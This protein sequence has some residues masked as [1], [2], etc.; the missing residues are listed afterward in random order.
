MS[1][2]RKPEISIEAADLV[3]VP[4]RSARTK[5]QDVPAE[6]I[7]EAAVRTGIPD[8]SQTK[9]AKNPAN[10]VSG[11]ER[12]AR[13]AARKTRPAGSGQ[14]GAQ[15]G[16]PADGDDVLRE[17]AIIKLLEYA[18]E[19]KILSYEELSDYLP[20]HISNSDK[21][22]QVLALLEANNVQLIEEENNGEDDGDS[23]VRKDA[24]AGKKRAARNDKESSLV[25]DPIRLYLREIGREHLLTGEQEIELSRQMEEGE[26]IITGVIKQ[27]GMIILE[28]YHIAQKAFSK[29]DLRELNLSK[30]EITEHMTERRRL[31]SFYKEALR[32]ILGDL[33]NYIEIKRRLIARG[34]GFS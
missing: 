15:T 24:E 13:K 3:S 9:T 4:M 11:G 31:S 8:S 32:T 2:T 30:K 21:I 20:E 34:G 6:T 5:S 16:K 28:F 33:K 19:K 27:S 26:N 25:D 18:K 23:G 1:D 12:K 29:R 22:E 14:P 10:R 17:S 7:A